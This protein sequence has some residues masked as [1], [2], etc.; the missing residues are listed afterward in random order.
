[1]GGLKEL[2]ELMVLLSAG[3]VRESGCVALGQ[4]EVSVVTVRACTLRS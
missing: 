1:M 3:D 2:S 4:G